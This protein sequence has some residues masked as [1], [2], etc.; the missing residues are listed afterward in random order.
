MASLLD[1]LAP[2]PPRSMRRLAIANLVAQIGITVTG[3]TV[4]V[5]GSGLGCPEFPECFP[6]SMVPVSHAEVAALH[7]WVEFG[8][9]LLTFVLVAIAGLCLLAA[10]ATR[11]RRRRLTLLA[12][13][14]PAGVL[15]QA[16]IGG[17]TVLTGLA[18]WTVSVHF[19]VSS[20]LVWLAVMLVA[21]AG[22][23]GAV[24]RPTV[25]G[26][27]RGLVAAATGV[28]AALLLAGTLV[29]AA[30]PHAGDA[31]TPRLGLGVEA[32][33]QVHA[34]L[35]FGYLGLLAGLGFALRAVAAPREVLRRYALLVAV[36][37]AQGA[38]GG[39]QYLLDVPEVLVVLHVLG[40]GLT[41][42]AA[43]R[44]WLGTADRGTAPATP[45]PAAV[46]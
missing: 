38:L 25:P 46:V 7:Q 34:E 3:A 33:A 19:L 18:W 4:R 1:R 39:V 30:G 6:G 11:P 12:A 10:L 23:G 28:L 15:V 31:D 16:A 5:T 14:M 24:P 44:L 8:N 41:T 37:L 29:T 35:L 21:A 2:T 13:A 9:R 22:E 36:V 42:A 27:I 43:A 32:V 45:V 20:V 40:A 26:A 17:A